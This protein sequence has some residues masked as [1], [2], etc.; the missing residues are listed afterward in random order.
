MCKSRIGVRL[1]KFPIGAENFILQALQL[2]S[3][4]NWACLYHLSTSFAVFQ[5]YSRYISYVCIH[6]CFNI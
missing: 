5:V 6:V 4:A 3:A 1:G 2:T